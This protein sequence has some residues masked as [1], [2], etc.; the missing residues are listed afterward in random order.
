VAAQKSVRKEETQ[1]EKLAAFIANERARK[2]RK[3]LLHHVIHDIIV[4]R[5]N[6]S[7]QLKQ[8]KERNRKKLEEE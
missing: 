7:V 6:S 4:I 1:K 5:K 3:Q 8:G 2:T